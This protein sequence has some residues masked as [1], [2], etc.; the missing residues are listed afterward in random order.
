VGVLVQTNFGGVLAI[1]GAPVGRELGR[2]AFK[3]ELEA[4]RGA[5][6][7]DGTAVGTAAGD[8]AD[9]GG[10]IM[11]VV[12]TD[13]PLEARNLDRLAARALMGLGRTGAT[14]SNGSGDYVIAFS[15]TGSSRPARV[16]TSSGAEGA[17]S[18]RPPED[19]EAGAIEPLPND[20]M[21][22]LFQAV[23]EATEEAIYNSLFRATTVR[24]RQGV[25]EALPL[26]KTLEVLRKYG[27]LDWDRRLPPG[28]A[29]GSPR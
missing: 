10:S 19:L 7:A 13:A 5:R 23:A 11:I 3:E 27:V 26:D 2:Y 6:P 20:A 28:R 17:P 18:G 22:P 21:S 29:A 12:A 14:M 15:T 8:S 24:G 25:V 1:N 4:A 16:G 9:G